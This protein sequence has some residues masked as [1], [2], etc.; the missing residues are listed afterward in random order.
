VQRRLPLLQPHLVI[1]QLPLPCEQPQ[2]QQ[3]QLLLL[4]HVSGH[5]LQLDML[6]LLLRPQLSQPL[7][8]ASL[9]QKQHLL[10]RCQLL[11]LLLHKLAEDVVSHLVPILVLLFQLLLQFLVGIYLQQQPDLLQSC[12][13]L[14]QQ[15]QQPSERSCLKLP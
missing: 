7:E 8:E 12:Q 4:Q 14:W 6:C 9:L 10:R 3:P 5:P 11:W 1:Y 2:D 15:P 13:L